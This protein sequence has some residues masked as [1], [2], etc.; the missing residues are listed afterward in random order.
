MIIIYIAAAVWALCALVL[1]PQAIHR[2]RRVER[3]T[4]DEIANARRLT[5]RDICYDCGAPILGSRR[6]KRIFDQCGACRGPD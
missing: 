1:I 4:S 5:E 2:A 6:E 3:L